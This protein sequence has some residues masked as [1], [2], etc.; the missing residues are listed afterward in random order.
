MR[1]GP[2][3]TRSRSRYVRPEFLRDRPRLQEQHLILLR[4]RP[5]GNDRAWRSGAREPFSTP[6]VLD[7][8]FG[9]M[10]EQRSTNASGVRVAGDEH[11]LTV[12]PNGPTVLQDAHVVQKMQHFN[13]ERVPER[14]VH[15][16]GSGAHGFFEVTEDVSAWT[17]ASFLSEVGKRTPMFARFSTVAGELGSRS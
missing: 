16:K 10:A 8:S 6:P 13:R 17:S 15:A 3:G 9:S 11:S 1:C 12:G 2:C 4:P 14:V 7:R 5:N